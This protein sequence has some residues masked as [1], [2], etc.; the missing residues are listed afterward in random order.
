M[1][2]LGIRAMKDMS[3]TV[4]FVSRCDRPVVSDTDGS[5]RTGYWMD[6]GRW[7]DMSGHE[8]G[9]FGLILSPLFWNPRFLRHCLD[10]R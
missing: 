1:D 10:G 4:W 7:E 2:P 6:R 9:G 5:G 8:G 3:A